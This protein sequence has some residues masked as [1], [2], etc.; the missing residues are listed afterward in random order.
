MVG[1]LQWLVTLGRSDLH[2]HVVTMSRFRVAPRQEHMDR[3]KRI[4]AYAI[5]TK[6][7]GVRFRTDPP[8]YS[9]FPKQ[10]FDWTCSVYGDVDEILP[11]DMPQPLGKAV[12]TTTM[13][14]ANLKHC[15]ATGKSLT[16][17]LHFVNKTTVDWYSKK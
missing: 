15:L 16:G 2:A 8:D 4:Y 6:D 14:Y 12:V 5:S 1:Q 7:Y 10:A 11:D 13:M 17:C 9:F 3:L